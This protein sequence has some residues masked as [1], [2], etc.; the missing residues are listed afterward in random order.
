V[1]HATRDRLGSTTRQYR[2]AAATDCVTMII[3]FRTVRHMLN[4]ATCPDLI[5]LC[6]QY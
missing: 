2:L 6:Y 4:G 5:A 1:S 3:M